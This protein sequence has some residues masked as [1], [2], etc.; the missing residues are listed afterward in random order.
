MKRIIF[1]VSRNQQADLVPRLQQECRGGSVEI[2]VDRRFDERRK[3]LEPLSLTDRR[4]FKRR[5]HPSS[6]DLPLIGID[7]VV[8]S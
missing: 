5:V 7:V 1:L 8:L 4:H 6:S 2:I 3:R